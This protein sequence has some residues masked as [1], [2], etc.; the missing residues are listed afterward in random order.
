MTSNN[1]T[2]DDETRTVEIPE[3]TADVIANRLSGTEFDSVDDYV[4][5][6][7]QQLLRELDRTDDE[8]RRRSASGST[9]ADNTAVDEGVEDRLESLGYL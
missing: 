7:L 1:S 9:E 5:F 8:K 6:A 2:R 3:Q 4:S